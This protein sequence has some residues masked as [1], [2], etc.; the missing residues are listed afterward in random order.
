MNCPKCNRKIDIKK[1]QT[2]DCRCGAKLLATLVK[3]NL[4]VFG[5]RK[6]GK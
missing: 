5:L 6:D 2:V 4:E 3:G 1:N